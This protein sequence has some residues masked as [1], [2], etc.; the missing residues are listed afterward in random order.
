MNRFDIPPFQ[1]DPDT[2]PPPILTSEP[3][4]FA[5]RTFQ[6]RIPRIVQETIELNSFP[7][8]IRDA[9]EELREEILHGTIRGL[10]E[11]TPDKA[12]WDGV[13]RP[14]LGHTW[15]DVPW[16]EGQSDDPPNTNKVSPR[17]QKSRLA[18]T[19]GLVAA[20]EAK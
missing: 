13:S 3:N 15:L 16:P 9:L 2:L 6:V 7:N 12:F 8:D 18:V 17:K 10:R 5:Q 20:F 1:V 11:N 14:Y 4:S 19:V